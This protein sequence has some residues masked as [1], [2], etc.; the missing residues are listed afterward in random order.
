MKSLKTPDSAVVIYW[1][2][3]D[4]APNATRVVGFS[5][6]LVVPGDTGK[7]RLSVTA[8]GSFAPGGLFTVTAFVNNPRPGETVTLTVPEN[9]E[10]LG[11]D[12][13]QPVPPVPPDSDS[14]VR[15]KLRSAQRS[16]N[17]TFKVSTS[18]GEAKSVTIHIKGQ[19]IFGN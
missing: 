12:E 16:G 8:N 9:L 18:S 15:W 11:G 7:D 17:Y 14:P 4:L 6:G 3:K 2:E 10:L 1:A 19:T 5:Y 13:T